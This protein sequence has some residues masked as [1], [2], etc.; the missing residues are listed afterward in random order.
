[1]DAKNN[2]FHE[3]PDREIVDECIR[4]LGFTG[5]DDCR[6]FTA[7]DLV[8]EKFDICIL[9]LEPYYYPCKSKKYLY[10]QM[11]PHRIL[12]VM[13]QIIRPFGYALANQEKAING[14]KEIL[15]QIIRKLYT[16]AELP[17]ALKIDFS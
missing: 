13:R 4:V 8:P 5:L 2:L 12:T 10:G 14:K 7:R 6:V 1:M 17:A 15:Y 3:V 9:L 11:T 16:D